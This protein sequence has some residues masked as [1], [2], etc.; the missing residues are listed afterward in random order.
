[1]STVVPTV[2][3]LGGTGEARALAGRLVE[4]FGQRLR[5]VSSL[6]GRTTEPVAL[7]GEVRRGGFGGAEG[8]ARY[9]HETAPIALIDATHPFAANISRNAVAAAQAAGVPRLALVRPPWRAQAGDRWIEVADAAA[10]ATALETLGPR[11]WLTLGGGDTPAFARLTDRWFLVR[12]VDAP[13]EPLPLAQAEILLARGPFA[14]A[15]ERRLIA[16]HRLDVLVCRASGGAAT[17]P[18]LQAARE[19]GIP[20]V[21]IRRPEPPPGPRAGSVDEA[22][23]WLRV[24]L[25]S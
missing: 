25:G 17:E 9:L 18:K 12:R 8:L 5:V 23:T 19:A 7:A 15:D 14:L 1:M 6:A 20:V 22:V 11:V 13:P 10:A 3:I 16:T 2:L 24:R 4:A 21:M